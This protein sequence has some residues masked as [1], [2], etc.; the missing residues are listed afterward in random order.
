MKLN[1]KGNQNNKQNGKKGLEMENHRQ[2]TNVDEKKWKEKSIRSRVHTC[3][4]ARKASDSYHSFSLSLSLCLET[5][6]PQS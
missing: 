4:S 5:E 2:H 1:K 6:V 3:V